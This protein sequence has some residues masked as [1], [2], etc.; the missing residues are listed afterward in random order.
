MQ[1][2]RARRRVIVVDNRPLAQR[3]GERIRAARQ[4]AGL[5]QRG[6]AAGRFTGAYISALEKGIAKPSMASLAYISERLGV[7]IRHFLDDALPV[8]TRLE[9]D[10]KLAAG[11]WQAAL[12]AYRRLL[13]EVTEKLARAEI[14]RGIAEALCRLGRGAD[15]IGPA[16]E[17][18]ELL[19]A[20]GRAIDAAH[21]SYWLGV[22]HY[23]RGDGALARTTLEELRERLDSSADVSPDL[24]ARVLAALAL[25]DSSDGDHENA[26]TR[27]DEASSVVA[28][29]DDRRRAGFL[30]ALAQRY[31]AAGD[32]DG[33]IRTGTQSVSLYQAADADA[34]KVMLDNRRAV[35]LLRLG[36]VDRARDLAAQSRAAAE[37]L[38]DEALLSHVTDTEAS[39]ALAQQD[40]EGALD[41]AEQATRLAE[42]IGDHSAAVSAHVT[43]ARVHLA[44]SDRSSAAESFERAVALLREHGPWSRLQQVLREWADALSSSGDH[45]RANELY[46]EALGGRADAA[47]GG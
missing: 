23:Q 5:S 1:K 16:T 35:A 15:A 24:P 28:E 10:V 17:A 46:R 14:L 27:L 9:A 13:G 3:I 8:W 29:Y 7:P 18:A 36:R 19:A 2:P 47:A 21:A 11:D 30:F 34:E 12:D 31:R 41:R 44:R 20:Q 45:E 4:A 26:L 37:H 40:Y 6:L 33:A 38:R 32:F 43:R 25:I 22:A 39:I 42:R